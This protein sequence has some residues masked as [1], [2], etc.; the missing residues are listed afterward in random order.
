MNPWAVIASGA[1]LGGY[2]T[3]SRRLSTTVLSGPMVLV[4]C[5]LAVGP[6]GLDLI[7]RAHDAEVVRVL[8]ESALAL[9][10]FTGAAAVRRRELHRERSLP[11]RLLAVGLPLTM[12][13]GWLLAWALLPGLGVWQLALIGIVL[14]PTDAAL[15]QQAVSDRRVPAPVRHGLS[16]ESGLNDGIV[17]PF[18]VLA[19]AA[20]AGGHGGGR[21]PLAAFLLAL[22]AS[23]AVG[24]AAGWL[25]A[26]L[27]RWSAARDRSTPGWRQILV[28]T[29]P[30]TTYALC[31]V[32]DG[33]GF[34]GAWVAGL[35]FGSA[36]RDRTPA[37][38]PPATDDDIRH[39]VEFS[40][41]LGE[42]LAA[43]SFLVFGAVILGPTLE[44][45]D[46]RMVLYAVLSLTLVRMVPVA[47]ALLGSG[48]RAPTVAYIGWFG[49]RGLA[50]VVFGLIA[51]EEQLPGTELFS[52]VVAVTVAFSV[53]A[54]GASAA[55]LGARYGS[56]Y[57]DAVHR[58]PELREKGSG[59]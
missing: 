52:A 17:L 18:F 15:G 11:V 28:L 31:V 39:G 55:V 44:R 47:V 34:I 48:L 40:D 20:A 36:L 49:P 56:W 22:V 41:R 23:S 33:S 42:L 13:L 45:I 10:L 14:A 51:F 32:I 21:G 16:V 30:A 26:R 57:A 2:A 29:V 38:R 9:V 43:L 25:G 5:G 4:T 1:V 3:V 24:L 35:A 6:L 54:H 53:Y 19:L 50:S 7:D 8:L 59:P 27:L 58:V 37:G 12:L 46:G